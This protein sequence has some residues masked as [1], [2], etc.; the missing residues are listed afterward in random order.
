MHTKQDIAIAALPLFLRYGA[1][2][3][4]MD[5]V[6]ASLHISKKT[7]YKWFS[8]KDEVVHD[9][10]A[11]YL[12]TARADGDALSR[13][14]TTAIHELLLLRD[15]LRQQLTAVQPGIFYDL[16]KYYP[17]AWQLW[18]THKNGYALSRIRANLD[19]GIR[20]GL[21]RPEVDV[22]VLAHL[23][24]SQ[25]ELAFDPDS[26]PN[27]EFDVARVQVTLLDHFLQGILTP[28]GRAALRHHDLATQA[29]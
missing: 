2:S 6:A 4:T 19:R 27:R 5:D 21:F 24:L 3:V 9:S 1:K 14:A 23:R 28:H 13:T 16:R 18:L 8:T 20:E 26:Y 29:A 12:R 25:I 15:W 17:A 22:A 7:I 10:M 11:H